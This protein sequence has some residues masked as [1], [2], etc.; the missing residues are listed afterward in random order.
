MEPLNNLNKVESSSSTLSNYKDKERQLSESLF[1]NLHV[2]QRYHEPSPEF[3][4]IFEPHMF[5]KSNAK[6]FLHVMHFI[7]NCLDAVEFNKRFQWRLLKKTSEARFRTNCVD[8]MNHLNEI[9][10][11]GLQT[12]KLSNI[13]IPG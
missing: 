6:A 9:H 2:M 13:H 12:L 1:R 7:C 3:L 5:I 8:Y 10:Q 4:Q 11:L